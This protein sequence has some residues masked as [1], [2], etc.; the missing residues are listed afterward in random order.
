MDYITIKKDCFK[1]AIKEE[2]IEYFFGGEKC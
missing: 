2:V 1:L